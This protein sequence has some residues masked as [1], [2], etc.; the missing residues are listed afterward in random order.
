[1]PSASTSSCLCADEANKHKHHGLLSCRVNKQLLVRRRH[2]HHLFSSS[3]RFLLLF[4]F[5]SSTLVKGLSRRCPWYC[6]THSL[7]WRFF[8][9]RG[10]EVSAEV[11]AEVAAEVVTEVAG[12]DP[13]CATLPAPKYRRICRPWPRFNDGTSCIRH[14]MLMPRKHALSM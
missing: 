4:G 7:P 6:T 9:M 14:S 10:V 11:A 3:W 8:D 2:A 5:V 13:P 12:E 1:M